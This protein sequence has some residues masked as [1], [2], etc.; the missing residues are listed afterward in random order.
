MLDR[1]AIETVWKHVSLGC[2]GAVWGCEAFKASFAGARF[3]NQ[4]PYQINAFARLGEGVWVGLV[5]LGCAGAVW[6]C[7]RRPLLAPALLINRP[8]QIRTPARLFE[9]ARARVRSRLALDMKL[10]DGDA[11]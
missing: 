8:Y 7:V 9:G 11:A 4:R 5:S 1:D 10:H 6:G 2:A 3:L